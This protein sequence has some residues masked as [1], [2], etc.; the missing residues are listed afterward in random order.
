MECGTA[1][2]PSNR[3]QAKQT[4]GVAAEVRWKSQAKRVSAS[5]TLVLA[6]RYYLGLWKFA[7]ELYTYPDT[8]TNTFN[9]QSEHSPMMKHRLNT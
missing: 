2:D 6:G 1:L 9:I 3:A 8:Q 5:L 4:M 7:T